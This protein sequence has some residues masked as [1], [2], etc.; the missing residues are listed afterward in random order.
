MALWRRHPRLTRHLVGATAVAA[1]LS[2]VTHP[3]HF[4][5]VTAYFALSWAGA[6]AGRAHLDGGIRLR[7]LRIEAGWLAALTLAAV[8]GV[9]VDGFRGAVHHPFLMARH[10]GLALALLLLLA[11]PA[12]TLLAAAAASSAPVWAWVASISYGLPCSSSRA[13][14]SGGWCS[15]R[16]SR[17]RSGAP[18][19]SSAG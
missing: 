14:R 6:A 17:S 15:P 11:T 7:S 4:S 9:A 2:F 1:Y 10:F 18:G 16:C 3:N 8:A 5:L 12:R 13:T 19:S